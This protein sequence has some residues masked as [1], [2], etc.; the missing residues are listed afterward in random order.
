MDVYILTFLYCRYTI[1]SYRYRRRF[2][3]IFKATIPLL[4]VYRHTLS[5]C[6]NIGP[7]GN[8]L[9]LSFNRSL[10]KCGPSRLWL[11]NSTKPCY[12]RLFWSRFFAFFFQFGGPNIYK[13][14]YCHYAGF[15]GTR[16]QRRKNYR[17]SFIIQDLPF[18]L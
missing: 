11:Q 12:Q 15:S 5:K 10:V 3:W 6:N 7:N 9:R 2:L 16:W 18:P 1:T 17:K 14:W 4:F 13:I 8:W